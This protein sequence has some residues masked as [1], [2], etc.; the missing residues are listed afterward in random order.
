MEEKPVIHIAARSFKPEDEEKH[1]DYYEN[2]FYKTYIP[3]LGEVTGLTSA[4]R[5][6]IVK[7]NPSYPKYMQ[8]LHF[9]DLR[10]FQEYDK[11]KE[12]LAVRQA[13]DVKFPGTDWRWY[14]QYQRTMSWKK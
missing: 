1:N 12:L 11:N 13:I 7:E 6:R 5:Y 9:D 10:S 2:W 8:I 3:L 4:E 14:V